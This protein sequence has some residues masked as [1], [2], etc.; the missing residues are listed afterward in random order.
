M[1][2]IGWMCVSQN[3]SDD[4]KR[5]IL[6]NF[7]ILQNQNAFNKFLCLLEKLR[8]EVIWCE[9]IIVHVVCENKLY[10]ITILADCSL[11]HRL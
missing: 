4:K 10:L 7:Q 3:L 11:I 9:H 2:S 8:P 6:K 5:T 1:Q